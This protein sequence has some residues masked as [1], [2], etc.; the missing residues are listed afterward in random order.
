M[1][2]NTRI[3]VIYHCSITSIS[4]YEAITYMHRLFILLTHFLQ[5]CITRVVSIKKENIKKTIALASG[6]EKDA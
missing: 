1:Y 4:I 6:H 2:I 5:L 3:H